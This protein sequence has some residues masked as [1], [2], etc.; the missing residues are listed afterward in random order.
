MIEF[1]KYLS[2][3][4][5]FQCESSHFFPT[6]AK[7][8]AHEKYFPEFGK[9]NFAN[10]MIF[11]SRETFC[12]QKSIAYPLKSWYTLDLLSGIVRPNSNVLSTLWCQTIFRRYFS[13]RPIRARYSMGSYL[14]LMVFP[15]K[16]YCII[17]SEIKPPEKQCLN[18]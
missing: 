2:L 13:D 6:I 12:S 1:W 5:H 18:N 7:V 15:S 16:K 11:W 14:P 10:F 4:S 17:F 9:E 8:Y 3:L